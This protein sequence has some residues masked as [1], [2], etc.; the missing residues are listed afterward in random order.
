MSSSIPTNV[1]IDTGIVTQAQ[2]ANLAEVESLSSALSSLYADLDKLLLELGDLEPPKANA[3]ERDKDGNL[4]PSGQDQFNS[5]LAKFNQKMTDVTG[6]INQKRQEVV[7]TE[8]KLAR[9]QNESGAAQAQDAAET[10]RRA[11][12][13][14]EHEDASAKAVADANERLASVERRIVEKTTHIEVP[15]ID[16]NEGVTSAQVKLLELVQLIGGLGRESPFGAEAAKGQG[17]GLLA[18]SDLPASLKSQIATDPKAEA[19]FADM[20]KSIQSQLAAID[21]SS[22][23]V[24]GKGQ[25]GKLVEASQ[26]FIGV[27]NSEVPGN[28]QSRFAEFVGGWAL[29]GAVDVGLL[30]QYV[31]QESYKE[32][33]ED[34]RFMAEKVQFFNKLKGNIRD[35]I[36][37]LSN[38]QLLAQPGKNADGSLDGTKL[39][40]TSKI[41]NPAT[42]PDGTRMDPQP[43]SIVE[44]LNAEL[45]AGD[46]ADNGGV[47][48]FGSAPGS[49]GAVEYTLN[50]FGSADTTSP[51]FFEQLE[52]KKKD[53]EKSLNSVGDDAQLANVDLQDKLQK[54]QQALQKVS[55]ISKTYHDTAMSVI[56]KMS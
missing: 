4:T 16:A 55:N 30:I 31:I 35:E 45:G 53:L 20:R 1:G 27:D 23:K 7:Q 52:G 41:P 37:R 42:Y 32:S 33:T 22:Q 50:A 29:K 3:F 14:Q 28:L 11:A 51:G 43:G 13:A 5:A 17:A 46:H 48:S 40:D 9:V 18:G 26:G 25:S 15:S 54:Q 47:R 38:L 39:T 49:N 10:Q 12:A 6:Q 44:Y 19:L 2:D 21:Q 24:S 56:R 8:G 34:L 36:S